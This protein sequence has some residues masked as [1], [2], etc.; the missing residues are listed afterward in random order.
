MRDRSLVNNAA[1]LVIC[2]LLAGLVVAA[3]A[4][5]A[6]AVTGLAAKVGADNFQELPSDLEVLPPPETS[7]VYAADGKT[8]ITGFYEENRQNIALKEMSP[9]I[10]DAIV[11]AE[12][13]RFYDHHGVDLKGVLRALVANS[14]AGET[15]QGASTLTMQY[16]RQALTYSARTAAERK[17][18]TARTSSRKIKEIRYAIALEKRL[19]KDQI[20]ENYL[21]IAYFGHKAY[22]VY[23]ASYAYFSKHPKDL[24][25][26]EAAMLAAMV[27]APSVYNPA[28]KDPKVRDVTL[29]R[30][31]WVISRMVDMGYISAADA[32]TGK[33]AELTLKRKAPPNS[34]TEVPPNHKDWGFFCAYFKTWWN[35]QK[36]F[37]G[38]RTERE[39]NLKSGGY[40]IITSLDPKLQSAAMKNILTKKNVH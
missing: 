24:K 22:G 27:R 18:A 2:G 4:F 26:E 6:L 3:A 12:D 30:R 5:P 1:S 34:C 8:R 16:V 14:G 25:L 40:K 28:S 13:T 32:G 11:A 17:S 23:A 10:R 29:E 15:K 20:L 36:A 35:E 37:G 21:N 39:A 38:N 31:N 19:S 33:Q 7:Y 9:L